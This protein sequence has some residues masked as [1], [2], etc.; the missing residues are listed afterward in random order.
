MS[1]PAPI[2]GGTVRGRSARRGPPSALP[3]AW[4]DELVDAALREDLGAASGRAFDPR[5]D[6][7]TAACVPEACRARG[8]LLAK[9]A[10]RL[11]GID[12]F[13][14]V[15][16][17]ITPDVEIERAARDGDVLCVGQRVANVSGQ[18]WALL[19]GERTALNFVQRMSGIATRAAAWVE[20]AGG[21]ARILDTRKTTPGL[22]ALEKYAVRCGGAENHRFALY[23]EVLVKDNHV[24]LAG[25]PIGELVSQVRARVGDQMRIVCEARTEE[26]ARAAIDGGAD[27]VLLDNF[28]ADRLRA[29]VPR[30]SAHARARGRGVEFEASGGIDEG[31]LRAYAE[32]GVERISIGALTHSA[33]AL[34]LSFKL[35]RQA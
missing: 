31:N 24:D 6:V 8:T 22:R 9:Q 7:T 33:P 32:S 21:R 23:D 13:C 4:I 27:V 18:A 34:D 16:E 25:R 11:A 15:F 5:G 1:R 26:E 17:R 29:L 14:R 2:D 3:V 20:L 10:G 12:V 28:P 19:A 30:L 35:E